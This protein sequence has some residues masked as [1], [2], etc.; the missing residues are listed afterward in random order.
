MLYPCLLEQSKRC[1]MKFY[2]YHGQGND[3][4]IINHI[5]NGR[6]LDYNRAAS[7][8]CRRKKGVGAD[9]L[10]VL[11]PSEKADFRMRIF[12]SDGSEPEMCGNG[13]RCLGKYI[14]EE[15]LCSS[16]TFTVETLGGIKH[17]TCFLNERKEVSFVRVNM[18]KAEFKAEKIP[19]SADFS[20]VI[21]LPLQILN[22][23]I[24]VNCISMGNPHCIIF[25][26]DLRDFPVEIFGPIIENY[27]LF[28]EKIN[29]EFVQVLAKDR[30][31]VDV[32]ERGVGITEACG[33][34]AC[35]SAVMAAL[36]GYTDRDVTVELPGGELK[37]SLDEKDLI[38]MSGEVKKVFFGDLS[39]E[40]LEK[41]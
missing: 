7:F 23:E 36:R 32:W 34:G 22:K 40:F 28:P 10:I 33:T 16:L 4:V 15:K 21:D 6:P 20:P 39:K 37:I 38:F 41:L 14:Y 5:N 13:I 24:K 35:A 19:V 26:K 29:V 31:K 25:C 17:L 30:I 27:K 8:I 18:G 1:F 2:K 3:F 9:G 12:N 11:L